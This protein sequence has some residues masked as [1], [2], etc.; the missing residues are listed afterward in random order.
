MRLRCLATGALRVA[1]SASF[2]SPM[3]AKS[4]RTSVSRSGSVPT[5][6]VSRH[7]VPGPAQASDQVSV[8]TER[9]DGEGSRKE[10]SVND[11]VG[12]PA[13]TDRSA[14][15]QPKIKRVADAIV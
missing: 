14:L 2:S 15:I 11:A 13:R 7:S 5:L 8:M 12:K 1:N 9:S 10:D 6:E 3:A 4:A